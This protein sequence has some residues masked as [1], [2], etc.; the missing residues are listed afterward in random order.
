MKG[1]EYAQYAA[2]AGNPSFR[3]ALISVHG[4]KTT[5]AWQKEITEELQLAGIL[6]A[7]VDYGYALASV[8]R[9]KKAMD[10]GDKVVAKYEQIRN[11]TPLLRV[12][13]VA[14]SFGTLA[15]GTAL[16]RTSDL[17]LERVILYASVLERAYPW[18]T[19]NRR[20][21]VMR[22]L[23][24]TCPSDILPKIAGFALR[25]PSGASGCHGFTDLAGG[26]VHNREDKWAGHS[27]LG[28]T[29]HCKN[30]WIPFILRGKLPA[31]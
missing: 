27:G 4:M 7:P 6:Y 14:H 25:G 22:V 29:L 20:G 16:Q 23:N 10:V 31:T 30:V 13:S 26:V 9:R 11:R 28:T 5:G 24:E 17:K 2:K 21:Q 12:C 19:I 3:K 8:L 15:L 18:S 1:N